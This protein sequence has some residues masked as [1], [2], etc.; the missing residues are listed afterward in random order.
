MRVKDLFD[1]VYPNIDKRNLILSL[2]TRVE[3]DD[4]CIRL[5]HGYEDPEKITLLDFD[6]VV[7]NG[8]YLYFKYAHFDDEI[9]YWCD[10]LEKA[11]IDYENE[12]IHKRPCLI[13]SKKIL[14]IEDDCIKE[15]KADKWKEKV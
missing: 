5:Y 15:I 14:K 9:F 7:R 4:R 1:F 11:D 2:M 13:M 6:K 8:Y 10:S 12:N 3:C